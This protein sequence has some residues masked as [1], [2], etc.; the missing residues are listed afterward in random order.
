[1]SPPG[2]EDV[3]VE[4][5]LSAVSPGTETLVYRGE[6][7]EF[8]ADSEIDALSG[9][10]DFPLQYGYAA[11]GTIVDVG[12]GVSNDWI[13]RRVFGFQPHASHFTASPDALIPLPKEVTWAGG[14]LIPNVETAV[15]LLMDGAPVLGE[16][17]LVYGQGV[18][19]LLTT[20]LLS[21]HPVGRL[22]TVEPDPTRR[23]WSMSLGAD[24][25][26]A[27]ASLDALLEALDVTSAEPRPVEGQQ[28][29]G[30]D[31]VYELSGQPDALN[32]ALGVVGFDGR[33]VLGSWYGTR[34]TPIDLG[35][36]FHRSRV[37]IVSSQVSTV[38]PEYQGRWNKHRR[39]QTVLDLLP[40]LEIQS[41][42]SDPVSIERAPDVYEQLDRGEGPLQPIFHYE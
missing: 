21:R 4:T 34:R 10:L 25:S 30:A 8:A 38:A 23:E 1:M 41:L 33:I 32:Q 40:E 6:A 5:V 15:N 20:A 39:M 27:P 19:G 28:Y 16:H 12:S 37:S 13:G 22:Y 3:V 24:R 29:D 17:A 9:G 42:I 7:P 35:G 11:V 14:S 36:R 26:F 18:V 2:E 31:L